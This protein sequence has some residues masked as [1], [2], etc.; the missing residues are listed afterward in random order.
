VADTDKPKRPAPVYL[1]LIEGGT[2]KAEPA[3]KGG[4]GGD[5]GLRP[6]WCSDDQLAV[7][8]SEDLGADW[9]CAMPGAE[10]HRWTGRRWLRDMMLTVLN[11]ARLV[12]RR[13]SDQCDNEKLARAVS[14]KSAIYAAARLAGEDPAHSVDVNVFDANDW[15]LNTPAGV[16]DLRNGQMRDQARD[17]WLA[18]STRV[19]PEGDCPKFYSFLLEATGKDQELIGFLQRWFGYCLTGSIEEHAIV[20]VEGPGGTGKSVLV[21]I[22]QWILGE[23]ATTAAMDLFMVRTG[24]RHMAGYAVLQGARLVTSSE[25]EEGGRWDEAMVK[26]MSGGEPITAN[27]MRQDP[28][29]FVPKFKLFLSG[30]FRPALRSAD[31]A[32]RRRLMVVPF[33]KKPAE[34]DKQL[35]DKLKAEGG[36]ILK[37]AVEGAVLWQR[38]GLKVPGAVERVTQEY[39]D[40]ENVIGQWIAERCSR[41]PGDWGA[42]ESLYAD[43]KAYVERRGERAPNA[44]RWGQQLERQGFKRLRDPSVP[45]SAGPR[46]FAGI[47]LLVAQGDLYLPS[48]PTPPS[49]A[50]EGGERLPAADDEAERWEREGERE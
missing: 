6:T 25:T 14:S 46:G 38:H 5:E 17:D 1:S 37:W 24:E 31:D 44:K 11:R 3:P 36:G 20:F 2:A 16:V 18:R 19:A 49:R 26:R 40:D 15:L 8:L 4:G 35:I 45:K 21:H 7:A 39:F 33:T 12:C 32:M 43:F 47:K 22:L 10:W 50:R 27:R 9:R 48:R 30:N 13:I 42:S 29:T 23:Y 34:I 41:A 28:V